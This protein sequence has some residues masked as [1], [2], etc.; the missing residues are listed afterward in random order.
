[1]NCAFV[2][3]KNHGIAMTE[4]SLSYCGRPFADDGKRCVCL[5][6]LSTLFIEVHSY[7]GLVLVG[8]N[9]RDILQNCKCANLITVQV[10][11]IH[12]TFWNS[13]RDWVK[14]IIVPD[15]ES[16]DCDVVLVRRTIS[17]GKPRGVGKLERGKNG[18]GMG[19]ERSVYEQ[20]GAKVDRIAPRQRRD[21]K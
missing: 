10:N 9:K 4:V 19:R 20:P 12:R 13:H 7:F 6:L 1:V 16:R 5:L 17:L 3:E 18:E 2:G 15:H 14:T 11:E 8:F 21:S